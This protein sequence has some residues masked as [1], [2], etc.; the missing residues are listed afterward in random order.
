MSRSE[1]SQS[2]AVP[3]VHSRSLSIDFYKLFSEVTYDKILNQ[4]LTRKPSLHDRSQFDHSP[5]DSQV[6]GHG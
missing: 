2:A 6:P 1:P 5:H 4:F 3:A